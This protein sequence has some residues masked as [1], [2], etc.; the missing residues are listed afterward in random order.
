MDRDSIYLEEIREF[1]NKV[2]AYTSD[3]DYEVFINDEKLQLA[4]LKLI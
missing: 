4:I 3:V 2:I 1:C